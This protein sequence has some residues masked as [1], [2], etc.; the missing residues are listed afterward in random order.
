M[1]PMSNIHS[2]S[3]MDLYEKDVKGFSKELE[4]TQQSFK[5][6]QLHP[7]P[8]EPEKSHSARDQET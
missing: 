3:E 5:G 1:G 4:S 6:N 2:S 8:Q 7:L